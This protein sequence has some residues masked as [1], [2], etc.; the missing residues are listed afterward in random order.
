MKNRMMTVTTLGALFAGFLASPAVPAGGAQYDYARVVD[1]QPRYE[2]HRVPVD[3]EI[4]WEEEQYER[5]G[6]GRSAGSTIVG[7]LIGGVVGNQ[8]GSGDGRKAATAAGA[9]LGGAIGHEQNRR[10]HPAR[11]RPVVQERCEI[12]RDYREES[13]ISGYEVAYRYRGE[14][15]HTTTREHPGDRIRVRVSV[16][17]A[18]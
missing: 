15:Y 8:F 18:Y 11:Y 2:T 7:A 17:P 14:T 5:V 1:V 4:C 16:A 6:G 13:V 10:R 9:L 12:Q 3:R